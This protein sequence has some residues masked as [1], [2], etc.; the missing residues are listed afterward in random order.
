MAP[1]NYDAQFRS[2]ERY[3]AVHALVKAIND[4]PGLAELDLTEVGE[5]S[6]KHW[7]IAIAT[8][9]KGTV[10]VSEVDGA[11]SI[12]PER[13]WVTST[14]L[15]ADPGALS[16]ALTRVLIDRGTVPPRSRK[17][18]RD[19][20]RAAEIDAAY[21]F[22]EGMHYILTHGEWEFEWTAKDSPERWDLIHRAFL[23]ATNRD[24]LT[25][26]FLPSFRRYGVPMQIMDI[27]EDRYIETAMELLGSIT[28][29]REERFS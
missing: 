19:V 26:G 29:A 8:R 7:D 3:D 10:T 27:Y 21:H 11:V 24:S 25:S 2:R 28:S 23:T 22:R 16:I 13:G 9:T 1:T 5:F 18:V 17:V 6:S 4:V 20:L 15:N 14:S 12:H